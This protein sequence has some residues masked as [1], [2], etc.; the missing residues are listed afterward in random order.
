MSYKVGLALSAGSARGLAHIGVLQVLRQENIPVDLIAG[1][2]MGA[3][4]GAAYAAGCDV[5]FLAKLA[6]SLNYSLF[7]D[8]ALRKMGLLRGNKVEETLR[9]LTHNKS[10]S[11]LQVP[12][13]VIAS[14]VEKGERVVFREGDV[15][16]AVRASMSVPGVFNPVRINGRL[17]VDGAVTE[18]LPASI[19]RE[20][21]ADFIIGVDVNLWPQDG[22]KR[23]EAKSIYEVIMLSIEILEN[24]ACN[25][26]REQVDVLIAPPL[27][28]ISS[29]DFA[30]AGDCI[31]IG[32]Q[33]ALAKIEEIKGSLEKLA[34]SNSN[35]E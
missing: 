30:K 13:A 1:S 10:F 19:L 24:K 22:S 33:A 2:S 29:I 25:L 4:I 21:G 35:S 16:Q 32:R 12:L 23:L 6:V 27:C 7:L 20:M 3:I 8:V 26:S 11:E 5:D 15:A 14:D 17:L 31:D 9:L 18:S 34:P 28:G